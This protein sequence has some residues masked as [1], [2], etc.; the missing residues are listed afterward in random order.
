ML[1]CVGCKEE[2]AEEQLNKGVFYTSAGKTHNTDIRLILITQDL[3]AP[4]SS[5]LAFELQND[6]DYFLKLGNDTEKLTL[7]KWTGKEWEIVE[8]PPTGDEEIGI[9]LGIEYLG[10]A[11]RPRSTYSI[12]KKFGKNPLDAGVYRLRLTVTVSDMTAYNYPDNPTE[13]N[14]KGTRCMV[15]TYFTI[16]PAPTE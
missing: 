6:T 8:R 1:F 9:D 14:W 12:A 7:K 11:I 2:K 16:L 13:K 4:H 15:E 3:T 5:E 10:A